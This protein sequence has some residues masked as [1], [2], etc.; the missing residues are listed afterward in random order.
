MTDVTS[1]STQPKS[2]KVT[3][4]AKSGKI[5]GQPQSAVLAKNPMVAR[6]VGLLQSAIIVSSTQKTLRFS[7]VTIAALA[8]LAGSGMLIKTNH[9]LAVDPAGR[10][11]PVTALESPS[12]RPTAITGFVERVLPEIMTLGHLNW[13]QHLSRMHGQYFTSRGSDQHANSIINAGIDRL[14]QSE[15]SIG[16]RLDGPG[17]Q[18]AS[19][20][21]SNG[22][23]YFVVDYPAVLVYDPP[24][25]GQQEAPRLNRVVVR[26]VLNAVEPMDYPSGFAIDQ[27]VV[28]PR[29]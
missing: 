15:Y 13:R 17:A 22:A 20:G 8:V 27:W 9:Y 25:T 24:G 28:R 4:Q 7:L 3:R 5:S 1:N 26:V 23:R 21:I 14:F 19:E 18:I 16:L 29:S 12:S 10:T 2:Q 11:Y 6:E